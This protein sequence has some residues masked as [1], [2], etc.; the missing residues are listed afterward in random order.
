MYYTP[1]AWSPYQAK[2]CNSCWGWNPSCLYSCRFKGTRMA[3]NINSITKTPEQIAV[4]WGNGCRGRGQRVLTSGEIW[5]KRNCLSDH[6]RPR[7]SRHTA[8]FPPLLRF[9]QC[10]RLRRKEL[11]FVEKNKMT[12]SAVLR[13]CNEVRRRGE[14]KE[15]AYQHALAHL[16]FTLCSHTCHL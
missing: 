13:G 14:L 16:G 9:P 2:A 5:K 11:S 4:L 1:S 12:V 3:R 7:S 6:T 10:L 15:C 8:P